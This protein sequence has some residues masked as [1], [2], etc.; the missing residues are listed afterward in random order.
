MSMTIQAA[1]ALIAALE[2]NI[3]AQLQQFQTVTGLTIH[4][5]PVTENGN[6]K[7]VSAKVKVQL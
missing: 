2:A 4:S 7:S 1:Q 6:G 5:V 3:T